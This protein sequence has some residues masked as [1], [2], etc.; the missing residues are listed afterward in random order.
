MMKSKLLLFLSLLL[1]STGNAP[2]APTDP[3]WQ[4]KVE[5][6]WLLQDARNL[7]KSSRTVA[8]VPNA[9]CGVDGVKAGEWGG[10]TSLVSQA[11][12]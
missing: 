1:A 4:S 3:A 9:A 11:I 2:G 8:C 5:A 12:M 7:A 6:D 10:P